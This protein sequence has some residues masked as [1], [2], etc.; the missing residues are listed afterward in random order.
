MDLYQTLEFDQLKVLLSVSLS[1]STAILR[2]WLTGEGWNTIHCVRGFYSA[3]ENS[4]VIIYAT[5]YFLYRPVSRPL[6]LSSP[7]DCVLFRLCR[8]LLGRLHYGAVHHHHIVHWGRQKRRRRILM[9]I[10]LCPLQGCSPA[11][12]AMFLG[13]DCKWILVARFISRIHTV[14]GWYPVVFRG[15]FSRSFA[16]HYVLLSSMARWSIHRPRKIHSD[17]VPKINMVLYVDDVG[18]RHRI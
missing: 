12:L 17:H 8:S 13:Y 18:D 4:S 1:V 11:S 15:R 16:R 14:N 5:Q 2:W 9:Q 7:K 3:G 10:T 6:P